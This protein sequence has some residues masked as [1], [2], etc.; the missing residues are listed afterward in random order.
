MFKIDP[1]QDIFSLYRAKGNYYVDKTE[2]IYH[3]LVESFKS[4]IMFTRPRRFG[5]TMVMTMFADFLDIRKDSSEVF[6]GLK[7][8]EHEEFVEKNMNK[9]PVVF[10]SLK[11][12]RGM[13]YKETYESFRAAIA[14]IFRY[15][16][17]LLDSTDL[18]EGD[19]RKFASL[20]EE[21]ESEAGT[22]DG[23]NFLCEMLFKHHGKTVFVIVD[24]YDV[25]MAS[26]YG[27][28][29]YDSVRIMIEKMLSSVCKT[30]QY[31]ES[32]MVSG[33]LYAIKNSAYTGL[34]NTQTYNVLSYDY[35]DCFGFTEKEVEQLL[36]AAG[37]SDKLTE[38]KEWYDGYI[39]GDADVYNPWDVMKYVQYAK[40]RGRA[41]LP[42][43][44]WLDTSETSGDLIR[45]FIGKTQDALESFEVLLSRQSV[46]KPINENVSY[47]RL[48][49]SG[50]NLWTGLLET[51]YLTKATEEDSQDAVAL[52]IP[53]EE[54]REA[55]RKEVWSY[56]KNH[57]DIVQVRELVNALWGSNAEGARVAL[58]LILASTV[59]CFHA[60]HEYTYH[61][62]LDGFFTG[63]MF[64]VRSEFETG[65]GRSDLVVTEKSGKRALVLELKHAKTQEK[66]EAGLAE[67]CDQIKAKKYESSLLYDGY[68]DI[69]KYGMAFWNKRCLVKEL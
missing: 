49:E 53:N 2:M 48:H 69:H 51:G 64:R 17:Y 22:M 24:E 54:I 30:N 39:F 56:F 21:R 25:P 62:V 59:S 47:H 40:G 67:A 27:T 33:C 50:E 41:R 65:Y 46:I 11:E 60:Y 16:S 1:S 13:D 35:A 18:D 29:W 57:V 31:I 66:L 61:L 4:K 23:L 8:M 43:P 20:K 63:Q 12:V 6:R 9:W 15:H 26:A 38:S 7:V 3:Y 19:K 44:F 68:T 45:G 58:D 52:R 42:L 34:N 32:V 14:R 28:K 36:A 10:L 37:L 55:F 5:K